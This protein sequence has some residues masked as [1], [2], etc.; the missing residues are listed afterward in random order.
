MRG[1]GSLKKTE[2]KYEPY[3][4]AAEHPSLQN[5]EQNKFKTSQF[6]LSKL[7]TY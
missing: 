4:R 3:P 6:S 7:S 5:D 1:I 2:E